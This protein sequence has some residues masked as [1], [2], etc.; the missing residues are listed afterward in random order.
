[1]LTNTFEDPIIMHLLST[2]QQM[3]DVTPEHEC[4]RL[5]RMHNMLRHSKKYKRMQVSRANATWTADIPSANNEI[6]DFEREERMG[7]LNKNNQYDQ[8]H[9]TLSR[10]CHKQNSE[11]FHSGDTFS[12]APSIKIILHDNLEDGVN[13]L[14]EY[15]SG[16]LFNALEFLRCKKVGF[17][18]NL[19][20]IPD[21]HSTDSARS[22][23][24]KI[25]E[26]VAYFFSGMM[27][28]STL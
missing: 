12:N 18:D 24:Q 15:D 26:E 9:P 17:D 27:Q 28:A 1:M 7:V 8:Q 21:S 13:A 3:H 2:R 5:K 20:I 16:V 6:E 23:A 19:D 14:A 4:E 22:L 25:M 10:V 11:L